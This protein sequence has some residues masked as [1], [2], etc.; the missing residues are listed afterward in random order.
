MN[1]GF[2][3]RNCSQKGKKKESVPR[4]KKGTLSPT[5]VPLLLSHDTPRNRYFYSLLLQNFSVYDIQN[6]CWILHNAA[7]QAVRLPGS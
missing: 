2:G 5:R 4:D 1:L 6:F 3:Q 7:P